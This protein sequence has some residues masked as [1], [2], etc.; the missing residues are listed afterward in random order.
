MCSGLLTKI[1][2][3]AFFESRFSR[4]VTRKCHSRTQLE[5]G[6]VLVDEAFDVE[7]AQNRAPARRVEA[8][9]AEIFVSLTLRVLVLRLGERVRVFA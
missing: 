8:E 9:D 2:T 5:V 1:V 3:S 6:D 4:K 7:L